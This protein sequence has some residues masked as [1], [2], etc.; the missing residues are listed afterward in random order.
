MTV[1]FTYLLMFCIYIYFLNLFN[2]HHNCLNVFCH[3]FSLNAAQ[4]AVGA[5]L[6]RCVLEGSSVIGLKSYKTLNQWAT[7]SLF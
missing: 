7:G 2:T 6:W 4:S 3:V 1:F 5:W